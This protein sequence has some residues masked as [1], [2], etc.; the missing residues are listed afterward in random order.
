MGYWVFAA[1]CVFLFFALLP[2]LGELGIIL[3]CIF[4]EIVGGVLD[5]V[6]EV[7]LF[8]KGNFMRVFNSFQ[9]CCMFAGFPFLVGWLYDAT[10]RNADKA[11]WAA[12]VAYAVAFIFQWVATYDAMRKDGPFGG[13]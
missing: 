13:D 7:V 12:C 6:G 10:F 8:I 11:F 3:C 9:L 1:I 2:A 4:G 5:C